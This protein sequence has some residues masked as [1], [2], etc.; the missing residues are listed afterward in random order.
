MAFSFKSLRVFF[1][2]FILLLVGLT[3][4]QT[5][6]RTTSWKFPLWVAAY[7]INGDGRE[8]TS[9]YIQNLKESDFFHIQ[10]FISKEAKRYNLLQSEPVV[11]KLAPEVKEL[12]PE[13]PIGGNIFSIMMWSLK[14]RYWSWKINTFDEPVNIK[15]FLVYYDPEIHK[16]LHHSYGLEKGLVG[17]AKV[18]AGRNAAATNDVVI[19]HELL[20]TVGATDKYDY[21]TD[22]PLYPDGYADPKRSPLLPQSSAE[23]MGGKI[24]LSKT[25][26]DIPK[27]LYEVIIGEKTAREIRW[28]SL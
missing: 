27:S 18:Y 1:L 21:T 28:I 4:W 25:E 17:V 26:S 2:S 11:F 9:R 6:S 5:Q 12:P 7:P 8:T 23:I 3:A 10:Q 13:P 16:V 14:L 20:H 19:T 15:L 24:P 22:Q